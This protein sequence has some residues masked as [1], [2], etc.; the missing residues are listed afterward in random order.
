MK[1]RHAGGREPRGENDRRFLIGLIALVVV[2]DVVESLV[3][4][5][6]GVWRLDDASPRTVRRFRDA[7]S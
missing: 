4:L 6:T 3:W 2:M 5:L 1:R 7:I